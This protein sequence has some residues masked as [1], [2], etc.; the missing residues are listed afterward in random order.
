[1]NVPL[2]NFAGPKLRAGER[3]SLYI[4]ILIG[5]EATAATGTWA[6][7]WAGVTGGVCGAIGTGVAAGAA[8]G[9]ALSP[10]TAIVATEAPTFAVSPT[11][12]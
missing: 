2:D 5:A 12:K 8:F 6:P 3:T 1:M 4:S 10:A 7:I 9:A 11:L